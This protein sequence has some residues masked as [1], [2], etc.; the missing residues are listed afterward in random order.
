MRTEDKSAMKFD[1]QKSL[2]EVDRYLIINYLRVERYIARPLASLIVR[3]VFNTQV[4]PNQITYFSFLLGI[5]SSI[6][7]AFGEHFY[8]I[9]GGVF[10][11]L[12]LIFDCADGMLAR[13]KNMTSTY[14]TYLDL[15]LDRITDFLI[16]S[17]IAIGYYFYSGNIT[18]L[19]ICIFGIAL[20]F[21][22]VTLY[23]IIR[24][25]QGKKNTG[26]SAEAR[27]L[28]IFIILFFAI[29]NRIDLLIYILVLQTLIN[30]P[31]K[32]IYFVRLNK[33]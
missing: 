7:F 3:A 24:S 15:F 17:G 6:L 19:I 27:S 14:G 10:S 26:D 8:F 23:Y 25:Y 12:S 21:L 11:L 32:I 16:F 20:Y 33:E 5:C 2:K 13:T 1:F 18:I 22:Q 28:T 9:L 31:L 30:I 29:I 4:T